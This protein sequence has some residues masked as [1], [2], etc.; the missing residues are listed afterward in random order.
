[1]GQLASLAVFKIMQI[2]V[3]RGAVHARETC[4]LG[5]T[6]FKQFTVRR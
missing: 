5:P 1:M 2:L 4:L 3:V 6:K